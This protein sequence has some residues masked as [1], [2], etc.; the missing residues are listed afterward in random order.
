MTP[1]AGRTQ[2]LDEIY[3]LLRTAA[4]REQPVAAMYDGLTA[5]VVSACVG[6]EQG[7]SSSRVLLSVWRQQRQR[8][9][10]WAGGNEWL[11]LHRSGQ[12]H[13]SR[14]TEGHLANRAALQSAALC[15]RN[16]FRRR[17]STRGIIR[18]T[19]SEAVAAATGGP[20]R[21]V[22]SR[23]S[24]DYAARGERGDPRGRKSGAGPGATNPR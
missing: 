13:P 20:G 15:R 23:S 2:V 6:P 18:K 21:C 19:G 24:A 7:R 11:A 3:A 4:A 8:L 17:C 1:Q 16:R 9:A 10:D 22:A 14:V 12:T 5:I